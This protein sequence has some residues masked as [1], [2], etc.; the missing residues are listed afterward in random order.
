VCTRRGSSCTLPIGRRHLSAA[1][2]FAPRPELGPRIER[3]AFA[4][5]DRMNV[6]VTISPE[7]IM[8][9][10]G[11]AAIESHLLA[12]EPCLGRWHPVSL[13]V[14]IDPMVSHIL[15]SHAELTLRMKQ[16]TPRS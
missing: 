3:M 13:G 14:V 1:L 7:R 12:L 15:L 11:K 16:G 9:R 5:A 2:V 6:D 8:S 10:D 4:A